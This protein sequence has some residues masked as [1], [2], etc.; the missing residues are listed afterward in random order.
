MHHVHKVPKKLIKKIFGT[1]AKHGTIVKLGKADDDL[2]VTYLGDDVKDYTMNV[3]DKDFSKSK[4]EVADKMKEAQDVI[5]LND[6]NSLV[7]EEPKEVLNQNLL[8]AKD[9]EEFADYLVEDK[10]KDAKKDDKKAMNPSTKNRKR[11]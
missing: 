7:K 6:K 3:A 2:S 8:T 11:I 9:K 1:T 4:T 5:S 10:T